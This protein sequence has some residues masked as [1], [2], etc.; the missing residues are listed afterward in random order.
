M[1]GKLLIIVYYLFCVG[2]KPPEVAWLRNWGATWAKWVPLHEKLPQ[3]GFGYFFL[4]IQITL[5][6]LTYFQNPGVL[7]RWWFCPRVWLRPNSPFLSAAGKQ[8]FD[9]GTHQHQSLDISFLPRTWWWARRCGKNLLFLLKQKRERDRKN[10]CSRKGEV[11]TGKPW[12]SGSVFILK[13]IYFY[14]FSSLCLL[15]LSY[16]MFLKWNARTF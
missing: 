6:N 3:C 5:N 9:P 10:E 14:L 4:G 2:D 16:Y 8:S 12:P 15:L 13:A 7:Q 1:R 11:A